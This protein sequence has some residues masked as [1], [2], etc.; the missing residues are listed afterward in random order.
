MASNLSNVVLMVLSIVATLSCVLA[1]GDFS[2][3]PAP[4]SG[5]NSFP[6]SGTVVASSLVLSAVALMIKY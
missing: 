1:Q 6:V 5:G 4:A 2:P 3:A